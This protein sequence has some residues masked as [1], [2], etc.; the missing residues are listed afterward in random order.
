MMVGSRVLSTWSQISARRIPPAASLAQMWTPVVLNDGTTYPYGFG[1][2][3]APV[4][5]HRVVEHGGAWQGFTMAIA[6]FIDDSLSVI[7]FTNLDED[8][9][10]P[11]RIA[12]H[13]AGLYIPSLM[14]KP[15]A[16]AT[17]AASGP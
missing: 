1:W 9:S 8:H 15:N 11:D 13:I 5:G 4:N 12:G 10:N 6:R 17:A 14:P 2:G 7:V 3:L 16:K